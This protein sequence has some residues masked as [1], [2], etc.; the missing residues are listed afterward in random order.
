M[1]LFSN[2]SCKTEQNNSKIIE[3]EIVPVKKR[4]RSQI[5][6]PSKWACNVRKQKHQRGEAYISRRGKYVPE[7]QVRNTKDCL[8]SCRYKCNER[9]DDVDRQ[10]IFNAFYSLN[11][12]EKKHFLLNTTERNYVKHNKMLDGNHKRKY[13]FKYFFLVRA[14][15]HTVCKNFYLGTLAISQK[16]VYNVHLSKSEMNLPKPDGRGLSEA[17]THSLPQEIKDRVRRHIMSFSTV[18][19]KPIKQFSRKK[20]YLECNLSIKQMYNIYVTECDKENIVPVKES[21]Y[22]KIFKQ[23]FNIHFKKDKTGQQLCYRCKGSIKKK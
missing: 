14:V 9:I 8:K 20:Q 1:S 16:P 18:D 23:E 17:S 12:N 10:H 7:R 22:R 13:S 11:A 4:A 15:R 3:V 6:N 2:F 5:P 19:S 21:M